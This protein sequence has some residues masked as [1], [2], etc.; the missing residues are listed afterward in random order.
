MMENICC[1][2]TKLQTGLKLVIFLISCIT[3]YANGIKLVGA[4]ALDLQKKDLKLSIIAIF[5]E[6]VFCEK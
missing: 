6:Y 3:T 1:Y 5:H 2:H 4:N